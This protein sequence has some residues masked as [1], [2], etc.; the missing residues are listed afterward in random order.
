VERAR[1]RVRDTKVELAGALRDARA[2]LDGLDPELAQYTE[3]VAALDQGSGADW[4]GSLGR[5]V[6]SPELADD[7]TDAAA[8]VA[9]ALSTYNRFKSYLGVRFEY[10]LYA[11]E[12]RLYATAELAARTDKFYLFELESGASGTAPSDSASDTPTGPFIRRQGIIDSLRFSAQLGKRLGVFRFR[13]GLKD[14]TVGAGTDLL[15]LRGRLQ[16]SADVFGSFDPT[17]RVKLAAAF[18]VLR[19]VYILGGID[20]ALN[21]PSYLPIKPDNASVPGTLTQIRHGRDYFLG[22]SISL[23]E[24]EVGSLLR[25]YGA[26]LFGALAR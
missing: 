23:G 10:D 21:A 3:V 5:L 20:D 8:T 9:D 14:S 6:N 25:V 17:P 1:E 22:A 24:D 7:I 12:P 19:R 15:L 13:A 18:A 2:G 4:K 26:L 16:L 11:R